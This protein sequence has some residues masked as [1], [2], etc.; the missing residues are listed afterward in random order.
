[1]RC[2]FVN[3]ARLKADVLCSHCGTKIAANYVREIGSRLVYCDLYCY[4]VAV[5][6]SVKALGYRTPAVSVGSRSS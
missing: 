1:M 2:V 3:G 4:G 6:A 5:E